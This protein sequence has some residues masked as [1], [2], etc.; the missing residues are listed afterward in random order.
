LW[1]CVVCQE[2]NEKGGGN[3]YTFLRKLQEVGLKYTSESDYAELA[4]DRKLLGISV[5]KRWGLCK[6]PLTDDWLVPG[7]SV[8]GKLQQLYR[9]L[10]VKNGR[11]ILM[12]TPPKQQGLGHRLLGV[13]NYGSAK[14]N[15]DVCEGVWDG[16]AWEEILGQVKQGDDKLVCTGN[17]ASSLLA[18][19]SV[20]ALP[21][22]S[23]F[24]EKWTSL[25]ADKDVRLLF[26]SDHPTINPLTKRSV[27][28]AG[29]EGMKR[30]ARLLATAEH[31]PASIS[32][33]HW[34]S[35]GFDPALPS[36][37]DVRDALTS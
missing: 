22:C 35:E 5:L 28:P 17:V 10:T 7:W 12:P 30:V 19:T 16:M 32:Y 9:Y 34:G 24:S 26:D 11:K 31:P 1:R 6:S 33:L 20:L 14:Q 15:I 13:Q 21:T 23:S 2:G 4:K 25:F 27:P 18:N 37:Y 29:F 8:D 36:G 3:I